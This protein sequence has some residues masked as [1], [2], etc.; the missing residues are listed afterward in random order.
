[1]LQS[2]NIVG[3]RKYR[4]FTIDGFGNVNFILGDN[5]IGKTS[6]LE[7]IYAWACGQNVFPYLN[8]PLA[9]GRYSNIQNPYWI[10]EEILAAVN[11]RYKIPLKMSFTG[12]DD[13]KTF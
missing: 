8:L 4:N 2:L 11:N 6:I 1:M 12:V 3:F 9:R 7:A 10:M 5:N 13:G